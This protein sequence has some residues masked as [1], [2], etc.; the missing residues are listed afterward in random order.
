D[1]APAE[2]SNAC[3]GLIILPRIGS[4]EMTN[5]KAIEMFFAAFPEWRAHLID[6]GTGSNPEDPDEAWVQISA[7]QTVHNNVSA[8][9]CSAVRLKY[10][11]TT[12]KVPDRRRPNSS[13]GPERVLR[14][15]PKRP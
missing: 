6:A 5:Q 12:V 10:P 9:A 7:R 11:I 4:D 2:I 13:R 3:R 15:P 8:S 14:T 1:K